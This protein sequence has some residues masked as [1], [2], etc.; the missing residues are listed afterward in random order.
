MLDKRLLKTLQIK[1]KKKN[2]IYRRSLW[3]FNLRI[4][5]KGGRD[6]NRTIELFHR[7]ENGFVE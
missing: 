1:K 4:K 6:G 2:D 3:I 5:R 7:N